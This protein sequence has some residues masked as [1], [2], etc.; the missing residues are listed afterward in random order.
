MTAR[1]YIAPVCQFFIISTR[2]TLLSESFGGS[3]QPFVPY[4]EGNELGGMSGEDYT[5]Q[6]NSGFE[7]K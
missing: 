7:L 4:T 5:G 6:D 1:N 3:S 2:S